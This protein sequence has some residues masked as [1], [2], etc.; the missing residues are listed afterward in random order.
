MER[1]IYKALVTLVG[2]IVV[3]AMTQNLQT[4][5]KNIGDR[6]IEESKNRSAAK[7]AEQAKH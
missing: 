6:R 3:Y 2:I 4:E 7:A 1:A 5:V